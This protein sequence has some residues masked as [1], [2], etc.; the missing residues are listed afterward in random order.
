MLSFLC[1]RIVLCDVSFESVLKD[2]WWDIDIFF[3]V[4]D[5]DI[6]VEFWDC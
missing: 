1:L 3:E 2:K 4:E 6:D 5:G